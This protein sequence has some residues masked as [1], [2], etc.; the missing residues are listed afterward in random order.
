MWRVAW[1]ALGWALRCY[2]RNLPLVL[3]LSA[4]PAAQRILITAPGDRLTGAAGGVSEVIV[5]AAR[6]LLVALLLRIAVRETIDQPTD[7]ARLAWKA[8]TDGIDPRLAEFL[9]QFLPLLAAFAIFEVV[10]DALIAATVAEPERAWAVAILLAGK[11]VTVIALTMTWLVGV[12][13]AY[14]VLGTQ[15]Q[16][17]PR[18]QAV[19]S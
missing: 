14:M 10:P 4:I 16:H 5:L 1:S 13:R 12:G 9:L 17:P 15:T 3:G 19:A 6:L 2:G 8:F 7:R 18:Q 11:N